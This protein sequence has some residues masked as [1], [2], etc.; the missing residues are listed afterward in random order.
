MAASVL[1]S[2]SLINCCLFN[3]VKT[4]IPEGSGEFHQMLC[5]AAEHENNFQ[6]A[7]PVLPRMEL[8]QKM[9]LRN[10]FRILQMK[11]TDLKTPFQY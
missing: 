5:E 6:R 9:E 2:Q 3:K 11:I 7:L 1:E 4:D 8:V 10:F